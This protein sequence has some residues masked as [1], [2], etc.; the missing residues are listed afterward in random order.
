MRK[1]IIYPA[2]A[3]IMAAAVLTSCEKVVEAGS[4]DVAKAVFKAWAKVN[5]KPNWKNTSPDDSLGVW[6]MEYTPGTGKAIGTITDNPYLYINHTITDLQGNISGSTLEAKDRQ[7]GSYTET[8]YYGPQVWNRTGDGIYVGLEE[9][10]SQITVG[11]KVKAAIP[12]WLIST[13][14]ED[15]TSIYDYFLNVTGNNSAIYEIEIV[16]AIA[17]IVTWEIDSI[18]RYLAKKEPGKAV[19]DSVKFGFYY[20]QRKAPTD[21]VSLPNDTTVYINYIGRRL[22]GKVFDTTIRDTAKFYYGKSFSSSTEYS[23]AQ[24]N[25]AEDYSDI[26]MGSSSSS[27]IDGFAYGLKR[28]GKFEKATFIFYSGLGY[29]TDGSGTSIPPYCPLIFDVELVEKP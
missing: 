2:L 24:I 12:G 26:T 20:I 29:S 21:T 1:Y 15:Y 28:M 3:V 14:V 25:M 11:S 5:G 19:S 9:V 23:P 27:I 10:L 13:K 18:G 6:F 8:K 7:T 17:D 16:D 4:N 22:D